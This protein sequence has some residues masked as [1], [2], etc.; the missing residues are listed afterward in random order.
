MIQA[1]SNP[2]MTDRVLVRF[3]DDLAKFGLEN[4]NEKHNSL[5]ILKSD[6]EVLKRTPAIVSPRPITKSKEHLKKMAATH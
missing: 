6:L 2:E 3:E 1:A 4:H 5:W